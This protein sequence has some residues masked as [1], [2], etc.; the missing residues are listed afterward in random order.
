V[1]YGVLEAIP[2]EP[3]SEWQDA[4]KLE[5]SMMAQKISYIEKKNRMHHF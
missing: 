4:E 2:S 5:Q 3:R 1:G